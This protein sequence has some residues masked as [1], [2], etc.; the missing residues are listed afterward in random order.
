[1][2][3]RRRQWGPCCSRLWRPSRRWSMRSSAN[4]L[5]IPSTSEEKQVKI[6][7]AGLAESLT[8]RF[9]VLSAWLKAVSPL[10][11]LHA[12]SG[13]PERR[14]IGG[15]EHSQTS[16]APFSAVKRRP[17]IAAI[18]RFSSLGGVAT[19]VALNDR[20]MRRFPKGGFDVVHARGPAWFR[21]GVPQG[22]F[23]FQGGSWLSVGIFEDPCSASLAT[24]RLLTQAS[25]SCSSTMRN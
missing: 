1:M 21:F 24:L 15:H 10:H 19:G 9:E 4:A 7:A 23:A 11:R 2:L 22:P 16:K 25:T 6:L 12:I 5:W 13:C 18:H 20:L 14:S 17:F 8:A 3:I